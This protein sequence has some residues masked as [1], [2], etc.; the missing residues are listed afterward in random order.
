MAEPRRLTRLQRRRMAAQ[1][2]A[3]QVEQQEP[4]VEAVEHAPMRGVTTG[5]DLRR[6]DQPPQEEPAKPKGGLSD[7]EQR[8]ASHTKEMLVRMYA[9]SDAMR[10]LTKKA[11]LS[12][13]RAQAVID[14]AHRQLIAD[15]SIDRP[16]LLARL[17]STSQ[18]ITSQAVQSNAHSAALQGTS[19]MARLAKLM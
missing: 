19:L 3:A 9:P 12:E 16:T 8:W 14:D 18:H 15:W 5:A 1:Q 2:A 11:S 7:E 13:T 10:F 6:D 17:L 4:S